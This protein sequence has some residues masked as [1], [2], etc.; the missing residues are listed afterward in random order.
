MLCVGGA[1]KKS[2]LVYWKRVAYSTYNC[3]IF[4]G[5]RLLND[6]KKRPSFQ[7]HVDSSCQPTKRRRKY[8]HI[9]LILFQHILLTVD[10]L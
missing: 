10:I 1:E 8:L 4:H 7:K 5:E 2:S 9:F 6:N 3:T